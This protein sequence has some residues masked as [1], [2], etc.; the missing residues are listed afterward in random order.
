MNIGAIGSLKY[1]I[2]AIEHG[3]MRRA[4][5]ALRVQE[6]TV[7]RNIAAIEQHFDILLFERRNDGVRLTES[8][9][10]W[11]EA[12]Q[13]YVDN[14]EAAINQSMHFN[15]DDKTLRIGLCAPAGQDFLLRIV[16]RFR[17]RHS[18]IQ[19]AVSDGSCER[20]ATAVLRRRLDIVFMSDGC[21]SG[22]CHTETVW[23]ERFSVLLPERHLLA[24]K[25]SLSWED[26]ADERLLVPMGLDGPQLDSCF[27]KQISVGSQAPIIEHCQASQATVVV[28]VQLGEGFTVAGE[29]FA[30]SVAIDGTV[31]RPIT[32]RNSSCSIK[33]VWL[34][35]NP[36][37]A[38]LHLV[39]I[40]RNMA[41]ERSGLPQE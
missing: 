24:T 26:L 40:A 15:A 6:S 19:I 8:G 11:V 10:R 21:Q 41:K 14:L 37:R 22:S 2:A 33:A 29:N 13:P 39:Q 36:K 23:T 27:L 38:V 3:S 7:S 5:K 35:S 20:Q 25:K 16:G 17:D 28:R 32:G 31:W 30:N 18:D 1:V 34:K 12:I 4:A 9:K